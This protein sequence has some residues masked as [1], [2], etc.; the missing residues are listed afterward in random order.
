LTTLP[1]SS[2]AAAPTTLERSGLQAS[3][4]AALAAG[5]HPFLA[6]GRA[7]EFA[8]TLR[9]GTARLV[10]SVD[11]RQDAPHGPVGSIGFI[12]ARGEVAA[13][14]QALGAARRW[15][16]GLGVADIRCPV[17]LST[18]YGHRTIV[19][20]FPE[21]G[22]LPGFLLE[23]Q[24][25]PWLP[26]RLEAHGFR[27]DSRGVATLVPN[28]AAIAATAAALHRAEAA[29]Y[30]DRA[31]DRAAAEAELDLLYRLSSTIFKGAAGFSPIS[32]AEFLALHGPLLGLVEPELVRIM[33]D[34]AGEPVGLAF[35]IVDRHGPR[36]GEPGAQFVFKT[37][38]VLP[39][40]RQAFPGL[41]WALVGRIHG[42]AAERGLGQAV[43]AIAA[44]GSYSARTSS[45]W[46]TPFRQ[47]ASFR[48]AP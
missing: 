9:A 15:L 6:F 8:V 42:L 48:D 41:G 31:V 3:I 14:D 5:I 23:P 4:V 1:G 19:A 39:A 37:I 46:G 13:F 29:G 32:A 27:A 33:E 38:G 26:G 35:A 47:Y 10:A 36:P 17:D 44:T 12:S 28:G 21:E 43:H 20:G 24:G 16:R 25:A 2:V 40:A 30:R 34:P 11:S 45:R 7:E 22:G 18:W